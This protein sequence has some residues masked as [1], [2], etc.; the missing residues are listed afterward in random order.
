[1]LGVT[2][3]SPHQSIMGTGMT[4]HRRVAIITGS[5]KGIGAAI[6]K[7]LASDGFSVVVNYSS[8]AAPANDVVAAIEAHGGTAIAMR[9]NVA[10]P[11]SVAR[12]FDGTV[13]AFGGVD[14]LVNNAGIMRLATLAET[15]DEL[16]QETLTINLTGTF[17]GMREAAK[18]LRDGGRIVNFSSSVVGLY[19]PA[20]AAY[21]ATKSA[22]EA[23]TH[24]VAKELGPRKITVNTVAPGPVGTD[25][26]LSDK[27]DEQ[28]AAIAKMS[29]AGRIGEPNDI[30]SVVSFLAGPDSFWVSGQVIRVN[31]GVV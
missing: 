9:A 25:L 16:W 7:R 1:M 5:S 10:E 12:L 22:V 17:N 3:A 6:A 14:V 24:V 21:A 4:G 26:F 27:S 8:N 28:V 30:A 15:S 29:P 31:G 19:Q 20:Y 13:D 18:R 2:A 23:M 11:A